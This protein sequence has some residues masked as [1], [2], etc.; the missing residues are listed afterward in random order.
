MPIFEY[1]CEECSEVFTVLVLGARATG[2]VCPRCGAA[3]TKKLVSSFSCSASGDGGGG[4]PGG[5][6][7]GGGAGHS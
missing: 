4:F 3:R 5:G 7:S 1:R 6:F 2:P